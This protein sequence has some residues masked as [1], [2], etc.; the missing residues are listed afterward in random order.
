MSNKDLIKQYVQVSD[1]IPEYQYR[2]LS[3]ND[4]KTYDRQVLLKYKDGMSII[5]HFV[6]Q[7]LSDDG[8]QIV[9]DRILRDEQNYGTVSNQELKAFLDEGIGSIF[10]DVLIKLIQ[11]Y[12][13]DDRD[14]FI[15]N[16]L[17]VMTYYSDMMLNGTIIKVIKEA[18]K[19]PYLKYSAWGNILDATDGGNKISPTKILKAY[20]NNGGF[21]DASV[22]GALIKYNNDPMGIYQ[23]LGKE[24]IL[25]ILNP[26]IGGHPLSM[27]SP[28]NWTKSAWNFDEV[29]K[30]KELLGV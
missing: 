22:L 6:Y 29:V 25:K 13:G 16:I 24:T 26:D 19:E 20:I 18:I 14:S 10:S 28:K 7:N 1:N 8:K 21:L 23:L 15:S 4:K 12:K 2:K 3:N 11:D 17:S 5:P 30:I 9:I 27:L